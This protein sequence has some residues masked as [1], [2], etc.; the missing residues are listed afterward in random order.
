MR[1]QCFATLEYNAIRLSKQQYSLFFTSAF[2]ISIASSTA[3]GSSFSS[4]IVI[5]CRDGSSD[6]I[7]FV[8]SFCTSRVSFFSFSSL[9]SSSTFSSS[10]FSSST[11]SSSLFSSSLLRAISSHFCS[12]SRP[13]PFFRRWMSSSTSST[14]DAAAR[15]IRL[16]DDVEGLYSLALN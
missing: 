14:I 11:F 7:V 10:L 4:S 3:F 6:I 8:S 1:R 2:T 16:P 13:E 5:S 15:M 9:F 12:K